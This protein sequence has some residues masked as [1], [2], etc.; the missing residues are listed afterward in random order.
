MTTDEL[1]SEL[2]LLPDNVRAELAYVL[3]HSL[4]ETEKSVSGKTLRDTLQRREREII[5]GTATGFPADE[6]FARVNR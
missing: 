4:N 1:K 5:D 3:L 6:V 2:L